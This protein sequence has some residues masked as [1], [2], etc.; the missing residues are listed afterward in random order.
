MVLF[1]E[2]GVVIGLG[3]L[4]VAAGIGVVVGLDVVA[5]CPMAGAA[6]RTPHNAVMPRSLTLKLAMIRLPVGVLELNGRVKRHV[7]AG[8]T[9]GGKMK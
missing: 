5:V 1:I 6:T 7:P 3:V 9:L 8:C 2:P 4:A